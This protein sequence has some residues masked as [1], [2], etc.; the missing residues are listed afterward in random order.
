MIRHRTTRIA[1]A[2][3]LAVSVALPAFAQMFEQPY[4]HSPGSISAGVA[5]LVRQAREEDGN[6]GAGGSTSP[7][8]GFYDNRT[9]YTITSNSVGSLTEICTGLAEGA[10]CDPNSFIEQDNSGDQTADTDASFTSNN[11]TTNIEAPPD[12]DVADDVEAILNA[13]P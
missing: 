4:N 6:S 10:E 1:L 13:G 2:A 8:V 11:T 3:G 9:F 12:E 5:A 7:E